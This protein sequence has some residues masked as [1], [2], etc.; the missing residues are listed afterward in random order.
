LESI[1]PPPKGPPNLRIPTILWV[2]RLTMRSG[3]QR[4]K[5]PSLGA[6]TKMCLIESE[7]IRILIIFGLTFVL[8]MK[9]PRVNVRSVIT[10]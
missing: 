9:G 10:F 4:P 6:F 5:S 7:I 3:M 2:M 1:E 8:Y